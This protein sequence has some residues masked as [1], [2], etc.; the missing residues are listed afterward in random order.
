MCISLS[1]RGPD[2]YG[3]Y[4]DDNVNVGIGHRRLSIIGL[5]PTGKQPMISH[6]GS[7]VLSFNGEIYNYLEYKKILEEKGYAFRSQTDSEVLLN[8]YLEYG[9]DFL[10]MLNGMFSLAIWDRNKKKLILARD[11]AG[12][13]PLYY[14]RNKSQFFFASEI[15][16]LFKIPGLERSINKRKVYNY[17]TNFWVSGNETLF[18]GIYKLEPGNVL[19]WND[20]GTKVYKW[21]N[22]QYYPSNDYKEDEWVEKVKTTMKQAVSDQLVSDVPLG[23]FLSGGLDSSF[24]VGLMRTILP[25]A[26]RFNCYTIK[27]GAEECQK[28]GFESDLP[29]ARLISKYNNLHL[30]EI[31]H[32]FNSSKYLPE[33]IY[34]MDEPDADPACILTFL[35]AKA[36]AADGVKVLLSGAGGDEVFMGYRSHKALSIYKKLESFPFFYKNLF[37]IVISFINR[38]CFKD[39]S[40]IH[41]RL[42]KFL[43]GFICDGLSQHHRLIQRTSDIQRSNL[44]QP[45]ILKDSLF[46]GEIDESI[47][48]A[49]N[50]FQGVGELH[51]HS[52]I[53][54]NSYLADHNF[55]YTDKM[56]MAA[57]VETRV[58]FVDVNLMKLVAQIPEHLFVNGKEVK[59]FL[60]KVSRNIVPEKIHKRSKT[61]FG[62]P[63]KEWINNGLRDIIN[64]TL[65]ESCIN[66]RGLFMPNAVRNLVNDN[67]S[68]KKDNSYLLYALLTLELWQ[69]TFIDQP[70]DMVNL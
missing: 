3:F 35:I 11:H 5:G 59:P 4:F 32:N 65:S 37:N 10:N 45:E 17:L 39:S 16:A 57:S 23:A 25:H 69:Q 38:A 22:L 63:M 66:K 43:D 68:G 49:Y 55:L 53:L 2:D 42:E 7:C 64:E 21:F 13:K 31:E 30:K 44:L 29:Y 28:E 62:V 61:G 40:P 20:R 67:R 41:R 70:G 60:S 26:D 48:K 19:I 47:K 56:S 8:M 33:A 27:Y 6:D 24:I 36:A 12:I 9:L 46:F 34:Y 50:H 14:Y 1:H 58:P 52:F 18:D 51:R 15:K 54:T